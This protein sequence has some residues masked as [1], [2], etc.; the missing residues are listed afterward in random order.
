M[1]AASLRFRCRCGERLGK[2]SGKE[3]CLKGRIGK[4]RGEEAENDKTHTRTQT[5]KQK[6]NKHTRGMGGG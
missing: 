3:K 5:N 1:V 4:K 2:G 6:T